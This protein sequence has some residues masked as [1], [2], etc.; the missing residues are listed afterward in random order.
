MRFLL[1]HSLSS[2]IGLS[3]TGLVH[4][5]LRVSFPLPPARHPKEPRPQEVNGGEAPFLQ[6][7]AKDF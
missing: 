2:Q 6:E 7:N 3:L 5:T 1:I 4:V